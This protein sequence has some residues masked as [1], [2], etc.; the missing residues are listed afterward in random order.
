MPSSN[1]FLIYAF[2]SNAHKF[3]G[4][5]SDD[6]KIPQRT[7]FNSVRITYFLYA[8]DTDQRFLAEYSRLIFV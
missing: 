1:I 3:Y 6:L 4:Q 5:N 7:F 2:L 8:Y